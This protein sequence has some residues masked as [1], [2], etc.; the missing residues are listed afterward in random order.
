MPLAQPTALSSYSP[1]LPWA[2][3]RP[4][5]SLCEAAMLVPGQEAKELDAVSHLVPLSR[6]ELLAEWDTLIPFSV[7]GLF[8][9]FKDLT[10][11]L[12]RLLSPKVAKEP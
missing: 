9:C 5:S 11:E 6:S 8:S 1:S 10:L 2:L 3:A 4:P 7:T 12:K